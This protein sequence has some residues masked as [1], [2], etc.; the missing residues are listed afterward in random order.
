MKRLLFLLLVILTVPAASANAAD[1]A[2][3]K[4]VLEILQELTL[5]RVAFDAKLVLTN[6]LLTKDLEKIR[7]DVQIKDAVG[8]SK[9]ALF[10]IQSPTTNNISAVDG[11]GTVKAGTRAEV[12]WLIIPS[13]GA[14]GM[15][16]DG[17]YY[18]VGATL[19]Y[20]V[21]GKEEII[22]IYP[23]R[24]NVK[25]MPE[26]YLD[27]FTP[28]QVIGDNPFTKQIEP[29]VPFPLAVR[30]LNDGYGPA[31]KL[32]I[33]SAQP[34]IIENNQGL[35]IDF[36]LLGAAVNDSIVSP[37]LAV[38]M[39]N[40]GSKRGAT[41]Y[42]EMIS[43]L[44]GK[45]RSFDVSFS[46]ASELGGELT[47][48]I[49]ETT[50]HYLTRRVKV[51]LPGRDSLL[52]FLADTDKDA[53]RLPDTIFE[54]EYPNGLNNRETTQSPVTVVNP[55]TPPLRPTAQ[56]P[57]VQVELNLSAWPVGWI[58]TKMDDPSQGLLDLLDVVRSDGVHLDPQNFWVDNLL[59]DNYQ[60]IHILQFIDYRGESGT[61]P[62]T[63]RLVYKQPDED[64]TPPTTNLV[65]SG[66]AVK[67]DITYITPATR[68]VLVAADNE[69]GSGVAA[70]Y[71]KVIGQ[72]SVFVPALPFNLAAGSYELEYYS[73]DRAN[74]EEPHKN[75]AIVVDEAAPQISLFQALPA[76]FAPQAP[77][78]VIAERT[79][80]FAVTANDAVGTLS[81]TVEIVGA[82]GLVLRTLSG[83]VQSGTELRL[84]WDGL[85][86]AGKP[87][88][89][90]SYTATVKVSDSLDSDTISHTATAQVTVTAADWFAGTPIDPVSGADQL[91]PA[92][93]GSIVVWQD[94]RGGNWDI[95]L[96]DLGDSSASASRITTDVNNQEHPAIDGNLIVWQ[97]NR[98]GNWDIYGYDRAAGQELAVITAGGDQVNPV[99]SG[100]WVAWQ[101]FRSGRWNIWAKNLVTGEIRQI[102][103][104]ERDQIRPGI[105]GTTLVWED[106][107][108]GLGEIYKYDLDSRAETRITFDI[109]NQTLPAV[110]GNTIIWIDQRDSYK[111]L[112]RQGTGGEEQRLTYGT[113]ERSQPT[114]N[115]ALVVYADYGAGYDDPNLSYLDLLTGRSGR[116]TSHPARQEEPAIGSNMVV[117]QDDRDGDWQIYTSEFEMSQLPVE[118][119]IKPGFNLVAVGQLLT[120]SYT[121]ASNLIRLTSD[122]LDI[123]SIKFY[124]AVGDLFR[125][126][127]LA[128]GDFNLAKGMGLILYAKKG[129]I[130]EVAA[131][132]ET[133]VFTLLPG[134]NHIGLLTVPNGYRAYDLIRSVGLTRIQS[135]RRYD[136]ETGLWQSAAIRDGESGPEI[137]GSNFVVHAGEG[138]V[139]TMKERLDGWK[140]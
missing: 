32:R 121:T 45:F 95:Y 20:T 39:G 131:S 127:D 138:L 51:N 97:D 119:D 47:S 17:V 80:T 6:N 58:Y 50:A 103:S 41:A 92:A 133:A 42:W 54:S 136:G 48:L 12:H 123:E 52:D 84:P 15:S 59:N 49:K 63:Y 111:H 134:T 43:T 3:A 70:M 18:F 108:H 57:E 109:A 23:D 30:V 56:A 78:G 100:E 90:G 93:F 21:A 104:H 31:N 124:D 126:A 1:S 68:I 73:T 76:T 101:D 2:C 129:G 25:P 120:S 62:G 71:R 135:V 89:A 9:D 7:V 102:T 34:E 36:K 14:G 4:V 33:D 11:T 28:Y 130:L 27:Y 99:I 66:P 64:I 44:S 110:S 137:V 107:R 85:D 72:N 61:T 116:L 46:H 122:T 82:D 117:W 125:E 35:L 79:L 105:S 98:G 24:I 75:A 69:G 94:N 96:K 139:I 113:D 19:T 132:G 13:P 88:P 106:Y 67:G 40:L 114:V 37:S 26:L 10:F 5:E 38:D 140:P 16:H 77:K 74:N 29:P 115:G 55:V 86:E 22:P 118:V 112:Y 53:Q 60:T 128:G 81:V 91:H 83:T 87:V 65:F 8:N